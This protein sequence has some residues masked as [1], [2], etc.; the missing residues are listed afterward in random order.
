MKSNF[1]VEEERNFQKNDYTSPLELNLS[2]VEET[3]MYPEED[4]I[5]EP[6]EIGKEYNAKD[7]IHLNKNLR[8]CLTQKNS[9]VYESF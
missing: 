7:L 6:S 8:N 2:H 5:F 3:Q 9:I 4:F 1:S